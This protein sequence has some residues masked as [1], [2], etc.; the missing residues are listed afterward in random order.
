MLDALPFLLVDQ[1]LSG[2]VK[3]SCAL[4]SGASGPVGSAVA[5]AGADPV[6]LRTAAAPDAKPSSH[7]FWSD[8]KSAVMDFATALFGRRRM[9][10][11]RRD[12]RRPRCQPVGPGHEQRPGDRV[13]ER[14]P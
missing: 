8:E 6:R 7:R 9:R 5:P 12:A 1:L 13:A 11:Q 3:L 14:D 10:R 4:N 2:A